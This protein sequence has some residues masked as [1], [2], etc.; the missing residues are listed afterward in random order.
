MSKVMWVVL[1]LAT[2]GIAYYLT[3]CP[4]E[5]TPGLWLFGDTAAEPIED[6]SFANDRENVPLCQLEVRS[7]R[8][9]SINLNCMAHEGRLY[10]SCSQCKGKAWSTMALANPKAK[11]RVGDLLFDVSLRRVVAEE[12]LNLAWLARAEKTGRSG[13]SRPDH[14]WSFELSSLSGR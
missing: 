13:A 2:G 8:P 3:A 1:V 9:H 12:E 10:V 11:V 14:W 4:C 6:W 7:W 5:R